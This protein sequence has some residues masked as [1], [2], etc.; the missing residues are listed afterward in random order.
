MIWEGG[1]GGRRSCCN[2]AE[3]VRLWFTG[4]GTDQERF[5]ELAGEMGLVSDKHVEGREDCV[6]LRMFTDLSDTEGEG[7]G[8]VGGPHPS[9]PSNAVT[10]AEIEPTSVGFHVPFLPCQLLACL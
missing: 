8:P 9:S 1:A 7:W 4:L 10:T 6:Q 2:R 5:P 3:A